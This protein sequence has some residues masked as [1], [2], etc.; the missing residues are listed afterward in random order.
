MTTFVAQHF[1][2]QIRCA[3]DDFRVIRAA[4]AKQAP[5]EA[6]AIMTRATDELRASGIL[7]RIPKPGDVLPAFALTDTDGTEVSSADL[8]AQGPLVVT[9][10]R[11]EW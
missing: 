11:G 9:V 5:P 7:D 4:F 2:Q 1:N 6:K 10:Y 8:L 3:I